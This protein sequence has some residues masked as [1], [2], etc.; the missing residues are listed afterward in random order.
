METES[1]SFN[2]EKLVVYLGLSP[3]LI[4]NTV[5]TASYSWSESLN[6]NR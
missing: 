5:R 1:L 4:E 2:W 6:R 3:D